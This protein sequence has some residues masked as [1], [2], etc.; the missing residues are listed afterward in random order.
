MPRNRAALPGRLTRSELSEI[1]LTPSFQ[2]IKKL[3]DDF[4]RIK[5]EIDNGHR[6]SNGHRPLK[7]PKA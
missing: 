7:R 4:V 6:P 2:Y 1:K 5:R 3:A